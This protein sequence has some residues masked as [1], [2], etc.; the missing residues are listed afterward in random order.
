MRILVIRQDTNL[1][2]LVGRLINGRRSTDG[3]DSALDSLQALNPHADL[4]NLRAGTVLLVPDTPS[5]KVSAT[6][7]VHQEALNEFLKL[8]RTGL[9]GATEKMK[10][11]NAAR[12]AERAEVTAVLKTAGLKRILE[13]DDDLKQQVADVVMAFKEDQQQADE[14]ELA[15]TAA[16]KGALSALAAL[17]KL[18]G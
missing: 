7:P 10:A 12:A 2:D 17:D 6:D 18:L 11:G 4:R 13:S 15:L 14:A 5:F 3:I 9:S 16:G 8:V 1:Q